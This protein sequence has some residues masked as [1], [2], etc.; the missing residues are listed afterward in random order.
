MPELSKT[1][2]KIS[3]SERKIDHE[4]NKQRWST[5]IGKV[6]NKASERKRNRESSGKQFPPRNAKTQK[7]E[8]LRRNLANLKY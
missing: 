5:G 3:S 8:I 6:I 1:H 4:P 2:N 7:H